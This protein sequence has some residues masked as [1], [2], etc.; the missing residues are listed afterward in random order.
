M[1]NNGLSEQFA[2]QIFCQIRGF[3][4]YGFPESHAASFALLVYVSA[5]L[6]HYYP[7][8]FAAALI[9]SQPM[10][11]YAPAQLIKD[12]RDHGVQV[13]PIDVN[14]S[15]WDCTLEGPGTTS[16]GADRPPSRYC[17][18]RL[19]LRMID[20]FSRRDAETIIAARHAQPFQSVDEF[21]GRT[22]LSRAVMM[23]LAGADALTSLGRDRRQA[24]W[25]TLAQEKQARELPLFEHLQPQDDPPARLPDMT[26]QDEVLRD[27]ETT[28]LSLKSHPIAFYRQQ[29]EK[30]GIVTAE[31]LAKLSNRSRV[32]V[33]G[34]VLLRQRPSTAKGITF[35]TLEDETG[36][37]NL[38]VHQGVWER[39]HAVTR[40]SP[41]WIARGRLECKD[42]V[43]H[44]VV[45]SLK[46]FGQELGSQAE[47]IRSKSR[48]FR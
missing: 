25:E 40:C 13:L 18:L 35:V 41:A 39:F 44:V 46:D 31:R 12:A 28:G 38:V 4:E 30:L 5:W 8:A 3:G 26:L 1:C 34:L 15:Q 43:I 42:S 47:Q 29:L 24:L 14:R 16:S 45:D 21:A 10:G 19:G 6:K 27:Y 37:V 20:G 17:H 7:D 36:T 48:D 2:E 23:R 33:A 11:F 32:Q 22:R 9:N